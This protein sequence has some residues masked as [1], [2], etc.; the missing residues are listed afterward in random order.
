[1]NK[2]ANAPADVNLNG[3]LFIVSAPSGAG[4]TSLVARLLEREPTVTVSI[5]HT[6]RPMRPGEEDGVNYFFVSREEFTEKV[7]AAGFLEYAEV[8]GNLYGTSEEWVDRQLAE[9]FDVIL[10]IDW[11]G[12]QQVRRQRPDVRSI[13]ILPPSIEALRDRL[14]SRG[15]DNSD[16][17]QRRLREAAEEISH[18]NEFDYLVV[19]DEFDHAV[20]Q[21]RAIMNAER[22]LMRRQYPC[23]A[24]RITDMLSSVDD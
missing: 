7:N 13:F 20:D 21:L 6:T 19:N 17:I 3:Q 12:A 5:S 22:L 8:F 4:K 18:F 10:E 1:M 9:G 16:V 11:Q 2:D 15:Q 23:Q 24:E 14:N